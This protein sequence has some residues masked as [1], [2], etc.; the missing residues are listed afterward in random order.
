MEL[1]ERHEQEAY[2]VLIVEDSKTASHLIRRTLQENQIVSEIVNDPRQTLNALKQFNPAL[3]LLD[4]Y[5]PNCTGVEVAR[6]IR[7]HNKKHNKPNNNQTNKTNNTQQ[8][9]AMRLGGDHFLTKPFNPVFLNTIVMS[10][11][12]RYRALR[13]SMYRD[14]LAGLLCDS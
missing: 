1:N 10:K 6:I 13:R 8:N 11:L 4:M 12:E 7:Q 2:R 14:S 9:D 3:I 5:M